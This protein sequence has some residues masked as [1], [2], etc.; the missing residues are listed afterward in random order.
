MIEASRSAH[1]DIADTLTT[2][3]GIHITYSSF[4]S[5]FSLIKKKK[6]NTAAVPMSENS[7]NTVY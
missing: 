5:L 6:N 3:L 2:S 1:W 7:E 4:L